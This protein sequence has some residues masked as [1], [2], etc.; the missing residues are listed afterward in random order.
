MGRERLGEGTE[1]GR[2][3]GENVGFYLLWQRL[4]TLLRSKFDNLHWG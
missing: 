1:R 3:V 4:Y 2:G